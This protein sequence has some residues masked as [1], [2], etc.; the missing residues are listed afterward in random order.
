MNTMMSMPAGSALVPFLH[1]GGVL[2][3]PF[4]KP[5]YLDSTYV[6]GSF[7]VEGFRGTAD[8]LKPGDRINFVRE[9]GNEHDPLAIL[10]Q[11][12][13]GKKLGYIPQRFNKIPARLMDAGKLLYGK[14]K[15]LDTAYGRCELRI[16][17]YI[18]D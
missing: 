4:T 1:K 15:G 2:P 9:P 16:G 7:Y 17:I 8:A 14:M 11:N 10:V 13:E 6:A 12:T 3:Q 18:Q 5:I